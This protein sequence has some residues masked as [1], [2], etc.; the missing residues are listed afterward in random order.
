MNRHS[1]T[2]SWPS[3]HYCLSEFVLKFWTRDSPLTQWWSALVEQWD[4]IE[5]VLDFAKVEYKW[6][7]DCKCSPRW[8]LKPRD[9]VYISTECLC[10][11][12]PSK[13]LGWRFVGSYSIK[14][15]INDVTV[16]LNLPKNLCHIHPIF[17]YSLLKSHLGPSPWD[18]V[19]A[20]PLPLMG[21]ALPQQEDEEILDSKVKY[22]KVFYLVRFF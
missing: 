15:C 14:W 9:T 3:Q 5:K 12:Q 11:L 4:V 19:L 7:A 21:G 16:E 17:H 18:P 2:E 20:K 13:K 22:N 10:G 6:F 1:I 8:E